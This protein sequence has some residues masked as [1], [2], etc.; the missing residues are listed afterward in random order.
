LVFLLVLMNMVPIQFIFNCACCVHSHYMC[1]P[2][3]F[4]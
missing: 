4:L 3:Q 2:T 1:Y